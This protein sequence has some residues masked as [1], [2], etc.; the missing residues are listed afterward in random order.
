MHARETSLNKNKKKET[1]NLIARET[2]LRKKEREPSE[3]SMWAT[4]S[5]WAERNE[6]I[7]NLWDAWTCVVHFQTCGN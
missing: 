4:N 6:S 2:S 1:K 7:R 3:I 5:S